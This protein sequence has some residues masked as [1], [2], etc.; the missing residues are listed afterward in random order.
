MQLHVIV[1]LL[2][3]LL[4]HIQQYYQQCPTP[5]VMFFLVVFLLSPTVASLVNLPLPHRHFSSFFVFVMIPVMIMIFI[6]QHSHHTSN[7]NDI[8]NKKYIHDEVADIEE[9]SRRGDQKKEKTK[10]T[11]KSGGKH[12]LQ[13]IFQRPHMYYGSESQVE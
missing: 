9:C 7:M 13:L 8:K 12:T 10:Q 4:F 1:Y 6:L 3:A 11:I 2:F 5:R